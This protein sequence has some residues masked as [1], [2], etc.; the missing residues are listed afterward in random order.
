MSGPL[1]LVPAVSSVS[2]PLGHP[3]HREVS[4]SLMRRLNEDNSSRLFRV[5]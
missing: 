4:P 1:S 3:S 2:N 5:A